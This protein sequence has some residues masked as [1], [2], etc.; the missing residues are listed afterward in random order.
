MFDQDSHNE[1]PNTDSVTLIGMLPIIS[2]NRDIHRMAMGPSEQ[3]RQ[4]QDPNHQPVDGYKVDD[5]KGNANNRSID[6]DIVNIRQLR[7]TLE[8]TSEMDEKGDLTIVCKCSVN[9]YTCCVCFEKIVGTITSCNNMHSMCS[10]CIKGIEKT[11]DHRCPVCRS[12]SKCHNYI[13]EYAISGMIDTCPFTKQGCRHRSYPENMKDHTDICRYAEIQCPWC[14]EK[15]TSFDLQE[16]TESICKHKFSVMSCSN[17][18]DFINSDEL[19]NMYLVSEME[20]SRIL[21]IKKTDKSCNLLCIQGIDSDDQMKFINMSYNIV[22]KSLDDMKLTEARNI[23]LPIHNPEHLNK[24]QVLVHSI[25]L[26]EL[27][28]YKNITITGF[29]EKYMPGGRWMCQDRRGCWY[30]ATIVS[31]RYN[32]DRVLVKFDEYPADKYDEWIE[33]RDGKY[34]KIRPLEANNGRTTREERIYV[35]NMSEDEQLRLVMERSIEEM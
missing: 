21:Y 16:H 22:V 30:R 17:H 4:Q 28:N 12:D 35:R 25:P 2:E 7:R 32:P 13:L 1:T 15:T 20:G 3:P 5:D 31:R 23:M 24:G 19:K 33:I 9:C 26:E 34:S 8:V 27:G 6:P 18:I 11:G 10:E 14:G 29:K